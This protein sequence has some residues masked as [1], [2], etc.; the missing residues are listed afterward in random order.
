MLSF[1]AGI[2]CLNVCLLKVPES[3]SS[4]TIRLSENP[5]PEET[6]VYTQAV[7]KI[8]YWGAGRGAGDGEREGV[9]MVT[10]G[11][12]ET[13]QGLPITS[14][15]P[16]HC[17]SCWE[18]HTHR[19]KKKRKAAGPMHNRRPLVPRAAEPSCAETK[20]IPLKVQSSPRSGSFDIRSEQACRVEWIQPVIPTEIQWWLYAWRATQWKPWLHV[21]ES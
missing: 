6:R 5:R 18:T 17:R 10:V 9:W 3:F 2:C 20:G 12:M 19:D 16:T 14:T 7:T 11:F 4:V 8:T 13:G 1:T 21:G 15:S